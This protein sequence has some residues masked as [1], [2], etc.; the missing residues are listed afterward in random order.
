MQCRGQ[1]ND[2]EDLGTLALLK[3]LAGLRDAVLTRNESSVLSQNGGK[4]PQLMAISTGKLMIYF[5]KLVKHQI[6]GGYPWAGCIES[7]ESGCRG[8][9]TAFPGCLCFT[10]AM[11][12][13]SAARDWRASKKQW[14][15]AEASI[16]YYVFRQRKG[17]TH[18]R[19]PH[20]GP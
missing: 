16:T 1:L 12:V 18:H 13:A 9:F 4:H 3:D 2:L 7:F 17:T 11:R 6:L 19:L 20:N 15:V 14:D 5:D 10:T 8:I